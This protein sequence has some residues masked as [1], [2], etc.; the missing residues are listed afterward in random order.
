MRLS[1]GYWQTLK[2]TPNDAEVVSQQLMI[3][4][5]L[6]YKTGAGLYTLQPMAFKTYKKIENIVREELDKI[7]C[8]EVLMPV[9]TPA[10]LWQE[11]GR[12]DAMGGQML[13]MKDRAERELCVSPT[14]EE[15]VTDLFRRTVNSYKQLPVCLY[16]INTKFRD[17]IRPRFGLMRAREFIMKDGYSFHNDKDS[18]DKFYEEIYG[19]YEN[20]FRRMG[21]EFIAVEA[22]GGTMAGGGAKTHEF[23]V[24]ADNG[25]DYVVTI[26]RTKFAANIEKAITVRKNIASAPAAEL[27]KFAT[28]NQKTCEEVC[29]AHGMPITQSLKSLIMHAV[30]NGKDQFFMVMLLGDDSLNEVKFKNKVNAE[31]IRPAQQ[32]ELDRLGLVKGFMGPGTTAEG[33]KVIY[34]EAIDMNAS[35]VVGAN[36]ADHHMKGFVPARDTKPKH[37]RADMR[38]AKEGDYI[39]DDQIVLKKGIEVGHIFQLGDKYTKAM[40]VTVLNEQGKGITPLMGCYG[41][42]MTRVMAAAIEQ[43]NDKDGIIWPASIAPYDVYLCFIGKTPETKALVEE[44]NSSIKKAGLETLFDDRQLGP[45]QMFK[46]A[47]LIGLPLRV[48]LGERDYLATG[49]IEVKIRKTGETLKVKKDDLVPTIKKKLEE[50]GRWA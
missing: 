40:K 6:I 13:K 44:L 7:N 9:I 14:N 50:L 12:W 35:Y 2:E 26:P 24:V 41:I 45:G 4:A 43:N 30:I 23:Q 48:T 11:S 28:P 18:L 33:F 49:E 3:R 25:E 10:E 32:A 16:H 22:D 47:D 36:E 46:D 5:G 19:A 42:G 31:H 20:I 29:A 34:D 27:T 38:L 37:F 1:Q 8:F 21:L 15:T 39:G 17:E